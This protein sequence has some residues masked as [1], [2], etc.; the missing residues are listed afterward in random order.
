[1]THARLVHELRAGTVVVGVLALIAISRAGGAGELHVAFPLALAAGEASFACAL[2]LARG[3][4]I[5]GI[6]GF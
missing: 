1:M 4:R 6:G 5:G 3:L 2:T